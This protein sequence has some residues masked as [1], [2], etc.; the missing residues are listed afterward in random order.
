MRNGSGVPINPAGKLDPALQKEF[1]SGNT[2]V[3]YANARESDKDYTFTG[4]IRP[5]KLVFFDLQPG[6]ARLNSSNYSEPLNASAQALAHA[7]AAVTANDLYYNNKI[8]N[9]YGDSFHVSPP[10]APKDFNF[11]W[12]YEPADASRIVV[13]PPGGR[14]NAELNKTYQPMQIKLGTFMTPLNN[15]KL[16]EPAPTTKPWPKTCA[17]IDDTA[18]HAA[19]NGSAGRVHPLER[20]APRQPRCNRGDPQRRDHGFPR[21]P[22]GQPGQCRRRDPSGARGRATACRAR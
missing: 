17:D 16:V 15:C 20:Q 22:G 21:Q 3:P 6:L 14:H 12:H 13:N 1:M 19:I 7:P 5:M 4:Q 2:Y 18:I 10:G 11:A 9:F 8:M